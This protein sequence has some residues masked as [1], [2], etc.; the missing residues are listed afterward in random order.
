[1]RYFLILAACAGLSACISIGN[2]NPNTETAAICD[3]AGLESQLESFRDESREIRGAVG[4][5][6]TN[7]GV[8]V[9]GEVDTTDVQRTYKHRDKIHKL[10]AAL[11]AQ[12]RTTIASCKS[13]TRCLEKNR[14][15]ERRCAL[16]LERWEESEEKFGELMIALRELEHK[17][18]HGPATVY[19]RNVNVNNSKGARPG[20]HKPTT[21]H[22]KPDDYEED[23]HKDGEHSA[24]SHDCDVVGHVFTSC[25]ARKQ[26]H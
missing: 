2:D 3:I 14:Y 17:T 15:K 26:P 9:G 12:Y 23:P 4:Y 10:D 22:H 1:M 11:D 5:G 16:T 19:N 21:Q 24:C 20:G 13:Y 25:C 18:A 8:A 7:F 6:N